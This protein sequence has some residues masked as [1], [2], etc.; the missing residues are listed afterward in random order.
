ML[1][2]IK[3]SFIPQYFKSCLPIKLRY[4]KEFFD[5]Y[6]L[7]G[8]SQWWSADQMRDY[9]WNRLKELLIFSYNHTP[10]Y[11]E[12]FNKL[13]AT[14]EDFS[15]FDDF[16]KFPLLTKDIVRERL[17]DLKPRNF[18]KTK[19]YY[20]TTGGSTGEPLG[21]FKPNNIDT[22]ESAFMFSQW[23]RVGFKPGDLRMILRGEFLQDNR[24]WRYNPGQNAWVFSS[25]HLSSTYIDKLVAKLNRI[26]P[27]FLHVYPSSLWVLAN[28][29][30]EHNLE[31]TFS[32][33]AILCGSENLSPKQRQLFEEIFH[34][35]VY[36]WLGL[37][38]KAILAGEC[39]Y[40]HRLHVFTEYSYVELI[41]Q[42]GDRITQAG[43]TGEIIGTCF[44]NRVTPFIRYST[45]DLA[46]Y[47][48]E[49]CSCGRKYPLIEKVEGR[50]Q[51]MI[52]L[53]NGKIVP[54]TALFFGQ[55]FSAF[56]TIKKMQVVQD[57]IGKILI[58]IIKSDN[59]S[60]DDHQEMIQTLQ[61]ATDNA[62]NI[63]IEFVDDIP[64][65]KTGKHKFLMQQLP[66]KFY[67]NDSKI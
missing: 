66:V 43:T 42:Q 48:S 52:V 28:L 45:G 26:K 58:R 6:E 25:Y 30:K 11:N 13:D 63:Q 53:N 56:N 2:K 65:T 31:L 50:I 24:L 62:L 33:K 1:H 54:L 38:E 17:S 41:S 32:P 29:I 35:R 18:D 20:Y 49:E 34:C 19:S 14:P 12:V 4:P 27:K 3:Q 15:G 21:F 36:S 39:E 8:K 64:R 16:A 23:A 10:Y 55:H 44:E 22:V 60:Q 61:I 7:L 37:A 47:A 59:F 9:Q 5:W 40:S 67:D 46:S 57:E 51:E